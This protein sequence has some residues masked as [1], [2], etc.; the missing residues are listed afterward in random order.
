[1]N[2]C[3]QLLLAAALAFAASV[4]AQGVPTD[5]DCGDGLV[6]L[7]KTQPNVLLVG[8]SISM[9]PPVYTPGGYGAAA[10]SLLEAQGV[11]VQHAG[12]WAAGGQC[13]NTRWVGISTSSLTS[14]A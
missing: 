13:S 14:Y 1:M 12:G 11:S 2:Q 3:P 9:V 10:R 6:A 8:D 4:D 7:S 5:N